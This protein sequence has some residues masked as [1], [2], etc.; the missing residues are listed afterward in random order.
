MHFLTILYA[1]VCT[2]SGLVHAKF[3]ANSEIM[4][5]ASANILSMYVYLKMLIDLYNYKNKNVSTFLIK[6]PDCV[7]Q[8]IR[9]LNIF[10]T[11][12]ALEKRAT[13]FLQIRKFSQQN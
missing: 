5:P 9:M 1:A 7:F 10:M 2:I 12:E 13:N 11:S 4:I 8:Y 6:I 3:H